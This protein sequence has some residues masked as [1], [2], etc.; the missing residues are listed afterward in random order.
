MEDRRNRYGFYRR[1]IIFALLVIAVFSVW[2]FTHRSE[3][4]SFDFQED[5]FTVTGVNAETF[6][7]R[8]PYETV[9]GMRLESGLDLG[10]TEEG[11]NTGHCLYGR[12]KS[13]ELG[14]YRLCVCS[15]VDE[16]IV[17]ETDQGTV[18][19]NYENEKDTRDLYTAMEDLL[20]E[21]GGGE[22]GDA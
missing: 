9:S 21:R 16:Y 2:Y 17:L 7:L 5:F 18:V 11:S 6:Q 22:T 12:W 14:E 13:G 4:V 3:T 8:I 10:E 1:N 20:E 19:C 15:G